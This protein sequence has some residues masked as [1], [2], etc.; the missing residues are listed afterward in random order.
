M[1]Y[2]DYKF[3]AKEVAQILEAA[4]GRTYCGMAAAKIQPL[5]DRTFEQVLK[6]ALTNDE[7]CYIVG[8]QDNIFVTHIMNKKAKLANNYGG[9]KANEWRNDR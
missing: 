7:P 5:L 9:D 8:T 1:N 6:E 2:A 4:S 3:N